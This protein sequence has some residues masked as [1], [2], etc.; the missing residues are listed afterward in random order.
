MFAVT[1]G[2]CSIYYNV[3]ACVITKELNQKK[4]FATLTYMLQDYTM[5]QTDPEF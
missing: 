1:C 5:S 2:I 4:C 3:M